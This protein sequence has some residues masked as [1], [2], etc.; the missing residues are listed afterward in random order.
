MQYLSK[1]AKSI[2]QKTQTPLIREILGLENTG[3]SQKGEEKAMLNLVVVDLPSDK[4]IRRVPAW[5]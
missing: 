3:R 4:L 2:I 5:K 1:T